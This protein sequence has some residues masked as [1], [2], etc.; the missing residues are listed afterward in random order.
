MA[1]ADRISVLVLEKDANLCRWLGRLLEDSG[2]FSHL[3]CQPDL[4][5]LLRAAARQKPGMLLLDGLPPGPA[6][7][8]P[9]GP[10]LVLLEPQPPVN[11]K[12][13]AGLAGV[14]EVLC[15][16]RLPEEL[17]LLHRRRWPRSG[18]G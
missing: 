6:P 15:R 8:W 5:G 4:A 10:L 11:R 12:R 7:A 18:G 1:V 13:L 9:E 3:G 14:H 17:A 16:D 2:L